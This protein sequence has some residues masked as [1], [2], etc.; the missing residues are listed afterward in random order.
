MKYFA[1]LLIFLLF[2]PVASAQ[3]IV[4][5][6]PSTFTIDADETKS[7]NIEIVTDATIDTIAT[8]YIH[9]DAKIMDCIGIQ[10]G[11]FF[12]DSTIWIK[13]TI[14]NSKGEIRN[15]VWA[16]RFPANASGT[17]V[18]LTFRGKKDGI[19]KITINE[20]ET[21]IARGGV[22]IAKTV[23]GICTVTVTGN[24]DSIPY[25]SSPFFIYVIALIAVLIFSLILVAIL[26]RPKKKKKLEEP[27][28]E[29]ENPEDTF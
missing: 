6:E 8:D 5:F 26:R 3:T 29:T 25:S 24:P 9:W 18:T 16:S 1:I 15:M 2:F 10:Q 20:T 28:E 7:V 11:D 4:K 23:Q 12:N 19:V 14:D 22:D 13:G 27:E 17:F 21:G